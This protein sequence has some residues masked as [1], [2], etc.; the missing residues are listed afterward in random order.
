MLIMCFS[1]ALCT[2]CCTILTGTKKNITFNS[3]PSDATIYT[4]K[5]FKE[6][7]YQLDKTKALAIGKTPA[8]IK[9]SRRTP[10]IF[11]AKDGYNDTLLYCSRTQ[12]K[13]KQ[14]DKE[15]GVVTITRLKTGKYRPTFNPV[16]IANL[17]LGG[18]V[19]MW[20]D[21]LSGASINMKKEMTVTLDKKK[22][23]PVIIF[24]LFNIYKASFN[25]W[26]FL[27]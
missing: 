13:R 3:E 24:Q 17:A 20:V 5:R 23:I 2:S 14:V 4:S 8:T 26:L 6:N 7:P 16:F 10:M 25:D 19:G 9:I 21:V 18:L 15:T 1:L 11:I 27:F 12:Y 22:E